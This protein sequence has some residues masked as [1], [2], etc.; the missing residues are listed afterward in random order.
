MPVDQ[1]WYVNEPHD[2]FKSR[3]AQIL[4][5]EIINTIQAKVQAVPCRC[6]R[7]TATVGLPSAEYEAERLAKLNNGCYDR[8]R[9]QVIRLLIDPRDT[10]HTK[11]A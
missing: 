11:L 10:N 5:H 8:L 2:G 7:L 1:W 3:A 6:T 9:T 4:T